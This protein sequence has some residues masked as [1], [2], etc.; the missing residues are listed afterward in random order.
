MLELNHPNDDDDDDDVYECEKMKI[1]VEFGKWK[2]LMLNL[3]SLLDVNCDD[4]GE[5]DGLAMLD[6]VM[7]IQ[8]ILDV[9]LSRKSNES[10]SNGDYDCF[11]CYLGHLNKGQPYYRPRKPVYFA[12]SGFQLIDHE[13]L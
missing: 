3:V 6:V 4:S 1:D 9:K 7:L 2:Q 10:D 12:Y 11:S 8:K 13:L 5:I